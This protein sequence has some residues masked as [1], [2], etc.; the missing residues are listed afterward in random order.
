MWSDF[1]FSTM[2]VEVRRTK[3]SSNSY[4]FVGESDKKQLLA[5]AF[6]IENIDLFQKNTI[7]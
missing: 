7:W 3:G 4:C 6:D 5:R 2:S 1:D